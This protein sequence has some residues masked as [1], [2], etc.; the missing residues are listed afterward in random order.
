ML[1]A[2]S[3]TGAPPPSPGSAVLRGVELGYQ[4]EGRGVVSE[5]PSMVRTLVAVRRERNPDDIVECREGHALI[6]P[7]SMEAGL[8]VDAAVAGAGHAGVRRI[9]SGEVPVIDAVSRVA[10]ELWRDPVG[11][12]PYVQRVQLLDVVVDVEGVRRSTFGA[13]FSGLGHNV[14]RAHSRYRVVVDDRRAD[15]ANLRANVGDAEYESHARGWIEIGRWNGNDPSRG[16]DEAPLPQGAAAIRVERVQA[17][18]RRADVHDVVLAA[19]SGDGGQIQ[20]LR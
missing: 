8:P 19:R 13:G 17:V 9:V 6:V 7:T 15:D 18:V 12:R 1:P 3:N 11:T 14:Q 2:S 5:H 20:R 4:A 10:D 16:I